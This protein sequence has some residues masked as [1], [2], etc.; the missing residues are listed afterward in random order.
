MT[1][2]QQVSVFDFSLFPVFQTQKE[3]NMHAGNSTPNVHESTLT[4]I[5]LEQ[6]QRQQ[7]AGG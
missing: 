6:Q 2:L 5:R 1:M 3:G 7:F 4:S